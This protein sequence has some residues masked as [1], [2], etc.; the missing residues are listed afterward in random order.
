MGTDVED[1]V[2]CAHELAIEPIHGG[3]LGAIA[4]VNA[5]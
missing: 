4:V 1:E 3:A 2:A 5:Q